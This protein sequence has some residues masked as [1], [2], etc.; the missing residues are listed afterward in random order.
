MTVSQTFLISDDLNGFE[1]I[2]CRLSFNIRLS[3]DLLWD[4]KPV[5]QMH[6]KLKQQN[7]LD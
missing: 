5:T 6:D 1:E 3:D 2:F 4:L 7:F